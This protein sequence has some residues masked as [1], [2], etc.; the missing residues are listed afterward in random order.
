MK[1]KLLALVLSVMCVA[2]LVACGGGAASSAAEAP[3]ESKEEAAPAESKEEAA[4]A[5]S[6]EEA[7][8]EEAAAEPAGD[9]ITIQVGYE[10]NP[11]EPLDIGCNAWKEKLDEISD[12]SIKIELFPSSQLG[13]KVDAMDMMQMGE[14]VAYITDGSFLG[15]YGAPE[16]SIFGA[17]YLFTSY[18]DLHKIP[19]TEWWQEQMDLLAQNGL[20]VITTNWEYGVRNLM[21]VKPVRKFDDLSGMIIR[22][23]QNVVQ[24]KTFEYMGAA[25]TGMA[26]GD[27]YTATQQGT[28]EGMENPIATLYGQTYYE[29]AKYLTMTEHLFV[30]TQFVMSN[31]VWNSLTEQQQQWL[32]EA[33]DFG[34]EANNKAQVELTEKFIQEMKDQG[35][36]V[37]ELDDAEKQ[38]FIDSVDGLYSDPEVTAKWRENLRDV[39]KEQVAAVG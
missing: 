19:Q 23:P 22:T 34:G 36:E 35:V 9:V 32:T 39:I 1:K 33:G 7:P 14:P 13:G 37:I 25:P 27:V 38:K 12:G 8:A 3:A 6:Q 16:L 5:E 30:L 10:N 31:D 26:L 21:T 2:S 18:D 15:D 4:P 29:V 20:H 28:I 11:G 17:P 24:V